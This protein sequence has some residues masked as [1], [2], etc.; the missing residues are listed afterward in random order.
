MSCTPVP[1]PGSRLTSGPGNGR[2]PEIPHRGTTGSAGASAW[3]GARA[4]R[5]ASGARRG[6]G[7]GPRPGAGRREFPQRALED[8]I[9]RGTASRSSCWPTWWTTGPWR[10]PRHP[11]R[12]PAAD[13]AAPDHAVGRAERGRE[14]GPGAAG[15]RPPAAAGQRAG[16]KLSKRRDPVAVEMYRA[17]GYLPE[18]FRN[19]LALLGWTPATRRSCR[20]T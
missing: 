12:G 15:V 3:R 11:G 9:S 6:R 4:V 7:G 10:S 16:K 18:A 19:Y 5:C 2:R 20:W 1:A 17:Q 8:F 13:H 14:R